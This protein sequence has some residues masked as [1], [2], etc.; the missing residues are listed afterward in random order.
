MNISKGLVYSLYTV[1]T[2]EEKQNIKMSNHQ[3]C[4]YEVEIT[5]NQ[6]FATGIN[7]CSE[8]IVFMKQDSKASGVWLLVPHTCQNSSSRDLILPCSLLSHATGSLP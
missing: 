8:V 3:Q 2:E 5:F 6:L 7:R 1:L 4:C